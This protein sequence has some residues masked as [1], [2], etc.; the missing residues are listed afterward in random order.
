MVDGGG[1]LAEGPTLIKSVRRALRL[2]ET[3]ASSPQP[4]NAK[5]LSCKTGI[6]LSTTYH[7]LRTLVVEG[8]LV[9]T[10]DR[11]YVLGDRIGEVTREGRNGAVVGKIVDAM[12]ELR[13]STRRAVY[14][15][16]RDGDR[17]PIT[18]ISDSHR[19]RPIDEWID[20]SLVPHA[21]AVG[22]ATL[23]SIDETER[24]EFVRSIRLP[25]LTP[26]TIT[27]PASL[28]AELSAHNG[29]LVDREEYSPG[30]ACVAVPLASGGRNG[31][32]AIDISPSR[33]RDLPEFGPRIVATARKIERIL[34]FS[35][36]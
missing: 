2:V 31:A 26:N 27:E 35:T 6:P 12:A 22:K 3:V 4:L 9:A 30:V 18:A 8:Y 34:A 16:L 23:A 13:Q 14:L 1:D 19:E 20:I 7:L 15:S 11:R 24:I 29:F 17:V 25:G 21:T 5:T 36:I 33:L 28:L 10:T 32:V